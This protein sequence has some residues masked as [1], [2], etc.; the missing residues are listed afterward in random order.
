[1]K[2]KDEYYELTAA[3]IVGLALVDEI[4]KS[5]MKTEGKDNGEAI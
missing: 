2:V 3:V 5:C 4:E 1:M